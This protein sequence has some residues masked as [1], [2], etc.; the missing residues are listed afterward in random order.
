MGA[1]FW[2]ITL[3]SAALLGAVAGFGMTVLGTMIGLLVEGIIGSPVA[4]WEL[5]PFV[6]AVFA[7]LGGVIVAMLGALS[8][9]WWRGLVIGAIAHGLVLLMVPPDPPGAPT[10]VIV[11]IYVVWLIAGGTAGA[12]GGLLTQRHSKLQP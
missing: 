6:V 2:I 4:G 3:L 11:W 9:R 8:S 5:M 7:T 1:R 10:A 12:L